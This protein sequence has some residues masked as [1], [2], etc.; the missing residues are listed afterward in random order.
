[1]A[2]FFSLLIRLALG[3]GWL[4]VLALGALF[5]QAQVQLGDLQLAAVWEAAAFFHGA[6]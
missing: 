2:D 5:A 4:W 6:C 1:V 3:A